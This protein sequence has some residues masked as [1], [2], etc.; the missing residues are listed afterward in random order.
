MGHLHSGKAFHHGRCRQAPARRGLTPCL[1]P[2]HQRPLSAPA[3]H[4]PTNL[5]PPYH[6]PENREPPT[7]R[8][9]A[10][11]YAARNS[12]AVGSC[13]TV[14]LHVDL[15]SH[16]DGSRESLGIGL[17]ERGVEVDV[18]V[19]GHAHLLMPEAHRF[20]AG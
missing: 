9:G 15:T 4:A 1:Q 18:Q 13:V 14:V 10:V 19:A 6:I 5:P 7:G 11:D 20:E 2:L 3:Q 17:A 16:F 8:A 12:I